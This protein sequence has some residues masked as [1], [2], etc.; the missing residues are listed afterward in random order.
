MTG[1]FKCAFVSPMLFVK[2]CLLCFFTVFKEMLQTPENS[3][4]NKN[5]SRKSSGNNMTTGGPNKGEYSTSSDSKDGR[6]TSTLMRQP[7]R[8]GGTKITGTQ[9]AVSMISSIFGGA[10]M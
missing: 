10:G 6:K 3:A 8:L 7:N 2:K 5:R 9:R 4:L 1:L